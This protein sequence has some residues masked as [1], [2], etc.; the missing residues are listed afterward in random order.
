MKK[1]VQKAL[2]SFAKLTYQTASV[3]AGM[4]SMHGWY[5][6]KAPAKLSK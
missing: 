2:K 5:Q 3:G 4:A 6:P 1:I